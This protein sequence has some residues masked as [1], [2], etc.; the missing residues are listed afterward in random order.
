MPV[1]IQAHIDAPIE[2]VWSMISDFGNLTRWHPQLERCETD[3]EGVGARRTVYFVDWSAVEELTA[4][5]HEHYSLS[6]LVVDSSRPPVIGASG[7]M[8]LMPDGA[9]TRLDWVSGLP[10]EA[11]H[12]AVVNAGLE[13][14]YPVR[15]GHLKEA[16]KVA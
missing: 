14:Y 8:K 9:G 5:S 11:E 16:L 1:S 6:Y 2:Q 10:D 12:A 4:V 15:I 3:G 13:A 7:C